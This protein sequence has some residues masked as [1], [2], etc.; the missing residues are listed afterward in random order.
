MVCWVLTQSRLL[1]T[2]WRYMLP[3]PSTLKADA[4]HSSEKSVTTLKATLC[5]KPGDHNLNSHCCDHPEYL[6]GYFR[7]DQVRL[8]KPVRKLATW[9]YCVPSLMCRQRTNNWLVIWWLI[10]CVACSMQNGTT[11][12]PVTAYSYYNSH[13]WRLVLNCLSQ[14]TSHI[15]TDGQSVHPSWWLFIPP[16]RQMEFS[17]CSFPR[18]YW[19]SPLIS[20]KFYWMPDPQQWAHMACQA[21]EVFD[22]VIQSQLDSRG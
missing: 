19:V 14:C 16:P 3:P 12:A 20:S 10:A 8:W 15:T 4:T 17:D 18:S 5:Q 2:S 11:E 21:T 13:L 7:Q 22:D 6:T 1:P 9:P